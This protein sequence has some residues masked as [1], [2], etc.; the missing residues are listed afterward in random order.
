MTNR[1]FSY[2]YV[3]TLAQSG[4]AAFCFDFC[5]GG[6]VSS[7]QGSSRNMSV[8]TEMSDLKAVIQFAKD[9]DFTD[10]NTLLLM[11]CSQGGLVAALTAAEMPDEVSGLILQYPALCIPDAAQKGEMLWLKF[12]P[13]H[14]PEKMHEEPMRLG[15]RYAA[16]VMDIDAF[17]AITG[18]T[19][20][21]LLIHGNR[22][23]IV[24]MDYSQMACEAYQ[25][26]G[27]DVRFV[28]ISGGKHIFRR[29]AHIRQEQ[30]VITDFAGNIMKKSYE[31][32]NSPV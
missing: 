16:D 14:I 25:A 7:S 17:Q 12:D 1:H 6:L 24:D 30:K 11:G 18:Y 5:G 13:D 21:V 22:D 20:K 3:K 23:T 32:D 4:Y 28:T 15:R 31:I 2:P 19:G 10:E 26:A 27:A 29:P 8:V 9:Q